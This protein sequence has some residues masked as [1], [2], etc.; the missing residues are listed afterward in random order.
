MD[1]VP[2]RW[3]RGKEDGKFRAKSDHR[4]FLVISVATND[5]CGRGNDDRLPYSGYIESTLPPRFPRSYPSPL[6]GL[7]SL[8]IAAARDMRET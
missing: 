6:A 3:S 4:V 1:R 7:F 5:G 2:R 8:V